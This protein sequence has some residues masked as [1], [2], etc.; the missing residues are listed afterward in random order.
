[1]KCLVKVNELFLK[2]FEVEL[3]SD[4]NVIKRIELDSKKYYECESGQEAEF[5]KF[6]LNEELAID[7][8]NIQIFAIDGYKG[9]T[10]EVPGQQTIDDFIE[11]EGE[12][13]E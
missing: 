6:L 13:N 12:T 9:Q 4:Q 11:L 3:I 8:D 10:E 1:M 2:D 5:L 7:E